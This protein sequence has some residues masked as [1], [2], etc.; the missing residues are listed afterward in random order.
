[1]PRVQADELRRCYGRSQFERSKDRPKTLK[2]GTE[3]A[4]I[5]EQ[6]DA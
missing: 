4:Q 5:I 6:G 2:L 1:M 3:K